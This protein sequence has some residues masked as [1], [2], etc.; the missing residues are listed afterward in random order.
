MDSWAD[1]DLAKAFGLLAKA[2][3]YDRL[4]TLSV[5]SDETEQT[6]FLPGTEWH[7]SAAGPQ[8]GNA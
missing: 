2:L 4:W 7:L 6:G 1:Q 3:T 8:K 5:T